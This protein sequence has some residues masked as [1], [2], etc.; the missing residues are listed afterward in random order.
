VPNA[1][2]PQLPAALQHD[3]AP[4]AQMGQI[5]ASQAPPLLLLL[6][7]LEEPAKQDPFRHTFP[8]AVQS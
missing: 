6:D 4:S 1:T 2:H 7:E 5:K 8:P 3:A